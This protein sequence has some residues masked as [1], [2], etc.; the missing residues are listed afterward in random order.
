M[1]NHVARHLHLVL[2]SMAVLALPACTDKKQTARIND[3]ETQLATLQEEH[4]TATNEL[5]RELAQ[6]DEAAR[7]AQA[8]TA[9]QIQH[10]TAERDAA[11]QQLAALK[12]EVARAEAARIAKIPTD[13][14]VPG[15]PEFNPAKEPK[16][17]Q[18]LATITGDKS[19]GTGFV[20]ATGGKLYLYT[21]ASVLAGNTRLS[22]TNTAGT[23]FTKFGNLEVAEKA[24]FVRIELLEAAAV[25]ALKL[26][27]D[28]AKVDSETAV[29]CLATDAAGTVVSGNSVAQGQSDESV[30][31]DLAML[32]GKTSGPL[33]ESATGKVLAIV[34][35]TA[36]EPQRQLWTEP[37]A[38]DQAQD[39]GTLRAVR[40]NRHLLWK[41]VPIATFLADARKITDFN[42]LTCV[43]EALAAL[44][45][46]SGLGLDTVLSGSH[47]AISVLTAAKDL[48]IATSVISLR[49]DLASKRYHLGEADLKKRI[50]NL[51]ASATSLLQRSETDFVPAKINPYHRPLAEDAVK[52]RKDAVKRL[53]G[54]GGGK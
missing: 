24:S 12:T 23:K 26:A 11:V 33:L 15:H 40:L 25:P 52:W 39:I 51:V 44:N 31:V 6:R 50:A 17:T 36:A 32:R 2:L 29:T 49:D 1:T 16:F 14:S 47:T 42:R 30:N 20:V 21:S 27:D 54:A 9:Q 13:P 28:D 19:T 45:T 8:D 22:I 3:L 48:P 53:Q 43:T 35:D 46:S 41:A 5:S 38:A 4:T 7:T 37:P 10:L 18:A 34:I